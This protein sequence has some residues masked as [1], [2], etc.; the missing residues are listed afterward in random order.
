M[1]VLRN[2]L[3][4]I[5]A[6]SFISVGALWGIGNLLNPPEE[7]ELANVEGVLLVAKDNLFNSTNPD[8]HVKVGLPKKLTV[9]NNDF[10]RHDLVVEELNLNTAYLRSG[11]DFKTAIVT[12]EAGE[13]EYYCTLHPD[14]MRGRIIAEP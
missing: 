8:I 12:T 13:Y 7:V 1:S 2:N 11:Q 4:A 14:T 9:V 6:V 5:I 3:I 10:S